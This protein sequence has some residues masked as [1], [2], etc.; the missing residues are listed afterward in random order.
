[1]FGGLARFLKGVPQEDFRKV[2]S[3]EKKHKL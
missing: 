1:V 3:G 2:A